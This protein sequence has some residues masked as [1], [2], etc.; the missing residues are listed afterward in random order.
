[1]LSQL[2]P[3]TLPLHHRSY[4]IKTGVLDPK[5]AAW[6]TFANNLNV[7]GWGELNIRTGAGFSDAVQHHA[8]GFLEGALTASQIYPTYVNNL[9]FTFHGKPVPASV[10]KFM[11][12]QD[13]WARKQVAANSKGADATFWC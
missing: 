7:T 8:A 10:T 1:M 12:E 3:D 9:A 11:T 2:H 5:A 13:A 6:G 4:S